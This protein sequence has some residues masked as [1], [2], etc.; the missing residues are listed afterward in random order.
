MYN[1]NSKAHKSLSTGLAAHIHNIVAVGEAVEA[2]GRALGIRTHVL[3]VQPV[4]DIKE[5]GKG[6]GRRDDVDAVAGRAPDGV[7][8]L[9]RCVI[10]RAAHIVQHVVAR[11]QDLRDR[12]LVV[13][14]DA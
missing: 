8:D 12:M 2:S 10:A 1:N 14:D 6:A 5:L 9:R 13:E 3:E 7:F 11:L 4:T